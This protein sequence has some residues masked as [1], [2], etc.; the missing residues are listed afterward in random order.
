M[1]VAHVVALDGLPVLVHPSNPVRGLTILQVRD[2]YTGKITN[3]NQVG[4][5]NRPIVIISQDTNSGTCETFETIVM[6]GEAMAGS[7]EYVGSNG[8]VRARQVCRMD[9]DVVFLVDG[10]VIRHREAGPG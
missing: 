7:V 2:I 9:D 4:G 1:P 8:A 5:P 3:W 10:D 6:A